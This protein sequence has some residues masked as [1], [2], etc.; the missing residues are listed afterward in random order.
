MH[1]RILFPCLQDLV[2]SPD[3]LSEGG[4]AGVR[5]LAKCFVGEFDVLWRSSRYDYYFN[6]KSHWQAE[7][8]LF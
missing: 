7:D 3:E 1:K 4:Q 2:C 5:C 8:E 6:G